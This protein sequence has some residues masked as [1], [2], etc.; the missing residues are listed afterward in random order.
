MH[1]SVV[2][3]TAKT[4]IT[5]KLWHCHL[6]AVYVNELVVS[7]G[8]LPLSC[9]LFFTWGT[10][11][12]MIL[13]LYH[14]ENHHC[15]GDNVFYQREHSVVLILTVYHREHHHCDDVLYMYHRELLHF[16]MSSIYHRENH[17]YDDNVFYH[18]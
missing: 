2:A 18:T 15:D 9:Y 12:V 7:E 17:H 1:W 4:S 16:V 11:V 5:G 10:S 3:R 13:R 6:P 14:R 8:A